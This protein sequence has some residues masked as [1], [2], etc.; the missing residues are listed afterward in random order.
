MMCDVIVAPDDNN[1]QYLI[2]E[3]EMWKYFNSA[4]GHMQPIRDLVQTWMKKCPKKG[5][6]KHTSDTINNT[7]P[8]VNFFVLL[9]MMICSV[10][11]RTTSRHQ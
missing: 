4:G 9:G 11:S 1:K 2:M 6:K 5:K 10:P 3:S 7:I 8:N